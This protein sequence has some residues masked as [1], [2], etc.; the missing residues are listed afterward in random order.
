MSKET[1]K[2]ENSVNNRVTHSIQAPNVSE[3]AIRPAQDDR[4]V[5]DRNTGIGKK[6]EAEHRHQAAGNA[7]TAGDREANAYQ[8]KVVGEEAVGGTTPTPAQN[9]V[10]ELGEDMGVEL[11]D[12]EAVQMTA[13][14]ENRDDQRWLLD[15]NSAED[16]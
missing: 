9:N 7:P 16:H 3:D 6:I 2:P 5:T 14:L 13:K 1:Q 11:K 10:D 12:S 15:P 4:G 8:A